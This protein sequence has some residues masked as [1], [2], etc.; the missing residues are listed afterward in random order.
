MKLGI[1]GAMRI[2]ID[3]IL[4]FMDSP[5]VH[6]IAN[7]EFTLGKIYDIDVIV[8]EAGI[9]MVNAA[10]TT[11][12]LIDKFEPSH[13]INTGIAGSL[14]DN[15]NIKDIVISTDAVEYRMD[16]GTLYP[17]GQIPQMDVY[18]FKAD[19]YLINKIKSIKTDKL[20][21]HFGRILSGDKFVSNS[22]D[23][24]FLQKN[25]DGYCVE[26]EGAAIAHVC[27]SNNIPYCIIRSISD[28]A[29]DNSN[30][31]YEEFSIIAAESST[32]IT[33]ELISKF[34]S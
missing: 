1:I 16:T 23:K 19:E 34:S 8:V 15:V 29:D 26:M 32:F 11:Q 27:Y 14:R 33:L 7:R 13:I 2:E 10:I 3:K 28:N 22:N 12:I 31:T 4:S 24:I 18:S 6:N 20:N 5:K 9:G 25:F 30:L 21:L 17:L